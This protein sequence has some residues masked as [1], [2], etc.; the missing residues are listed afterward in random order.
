MGSRIA[1]NSTVADQLLSEKLNYEMEVEQQSRD[2]SKVPESI[3]D[4]LS[5]SGFQVR[6]DTLLKNARIVSDCE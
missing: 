3:Q 6:A 5:K 4:Y 2:S 1:D